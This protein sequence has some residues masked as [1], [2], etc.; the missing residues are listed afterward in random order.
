MAEEFP[1]GASALHPG[2]PDAKFNVSGLY[3]HDAVVAAYLRFVEVAF[4]VR[5]PVD[6]MHG[7]PDV[8]WNGGRMARPVT[9][10][11]RLQQSVISL[12]QKNIGC[13]PTFSNHALEAA[14]LAD[15]VCNAMLDGVAARPDINGVIVSSEL[16]SRY[17]AERYPKLPQVASAVKVTVEKGRGRADYYRAAGERFHRYVVHPDDGRDLR[18]LEQ[19][20]RDK[21]EI[22]VNEPCLRDCPT[23]ERHYELIA[24]ATREC[25]QLAG[26][27]ANL[28]KGA[29]LPPAT[30]ALQD[31]GEVCQSTPIT[32]QLKAHRANCNFTADHFKKVYDLGFRRFKL[33]GRSEQ[34]F[35]YIYDLIRYT[36][37]PDYAAPL[38]FKIMCVGMQVEGSGAGTAA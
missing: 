18:L 19:L 14:D 26:G 2:W 21:A 5:G 7:A 17:I 10:R 25:A 29:P 16:L 24:R 30:Q 8:R 22:L 23:R 27:A 1:T 15:P 20:D 37:E 3:T 11:A 6:A 13:F 36:L 38:M 33:Q 34:I 32:K 35:V 31:F 12:G 28:P 4:G 9:D